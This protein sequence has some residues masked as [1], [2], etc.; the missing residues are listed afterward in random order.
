MAAKALRICFGVPI[1]VDMLSKEFNVK[2]GGKMECHLCGRKNPQENNFCGNCGKP[3]QRRATAS[4][5]DLVELMVQ[6][7]GEPPY[8]IKI[9][10]LSDSWVCVCQVL[11]EGDEDWASYANPDLASW[12]AVKEAIAGYL[13][14]LKFQAPQ[15]VLFATTKMEA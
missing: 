9:L 7:S 1:S 6:E 14:G 13:S 5:R 12:R 2:P 11:S 3:V 15:A 4:V 10:A 8:P